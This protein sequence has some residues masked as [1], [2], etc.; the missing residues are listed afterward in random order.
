MREPREF[1]A[2]VIVVGAL[3]LFVQ[4]QPKPTGPT[5]FRTIS[6][7]TDEPTEQPTPVPTLDPIEAQI[8]GYVRQ[9]GG[10][11]AT[12]REIVALDCASLAIR[13]KTVESEMDALDPAG[14]SF[15]AA[16]GYS[17]AVVWRRLQLRC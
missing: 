1:V 16:F 8:I 5:G 10:E 11:T 15:H 13:Q 3:A 14:T 6:L 9:Y 12:Y 17:R 2:A 4:L 7:P